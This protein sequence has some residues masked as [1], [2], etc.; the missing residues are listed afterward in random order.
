VQKKNASAHRNVTRPH[1]T[2][3]NYNNDTSK[4]CQAVIKIKSKDYLVDKLKNSYSI[5]YDRRGDD[6]YKIPATIRGNKLYAYYQRS[7]LDAIQAAIDEQSKI[8]TT[9][10]LSNAIFIT[11]TQQYDPENEE[12]IEETWK[13]AKNLKKMSKFKRK[14]KQ[15]GVKAY[16]M[17]V[18]STENGGCHHHAILIMDKLWDYVEIRDQKT[19]EIEYRIKS[20]QLRTDIKQAW[21]DALDR[22][23]DRAFVDLKMAV[24]ERAINYVTK[25]LGK[26]SSVEDALRRT[27]KDQDTASDRKKILLHYYAGKYRLRLITI[28]QSIAAIVP[29]ET[30]EGEQ[31]PRDESDL[32]NNVITQ[33]YPDNTTADTIILRKKILL[34]L[35]KYADISPY[36]GRLDPQGA[37]YRAIMAIFR[38]RSGAVII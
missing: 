5:R 25:E 24:D 30:K 29:P 32:I 19:N 2:V 22:P 8:D 15:L 23:M 16:A 26:A 13:N 10:R 21:A 20:E 28:S 7:R 18:E 6:I 36:T 35:V 14:L 17:V 33:Q 12:S 9:Q 27:E 1:S 34:D 3:A 4:A 38:I 37:E 31:L 11:L